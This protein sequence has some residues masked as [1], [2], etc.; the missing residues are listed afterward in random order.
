MV[1]SDSFRQLK[2]KLIEI[3]A[4]SLCIGLSIGKYIMVQVLD[5]IVKP[6]GVFV[7]KYS[8]QSIITIGKLTYCVFLSR[9]MQW[10]WIPLEELYRE[11]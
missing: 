5:H 6:P 9:N 11:H 7:G 4:Y 3:F 8:I 2:I 10:S 1:D